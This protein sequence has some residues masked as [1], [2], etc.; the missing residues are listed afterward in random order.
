MSETKSNLLDIIDMVKRYAFRFANFGI[1]LLGLASFTI[2][3]WYFDPI[4]DLS[5]K[6]VVTLIYA[7]IPFLNF[8]DGFNTELKRS[9]FNFT[10]FWL[11]ILPTGTLIAVLAHR[12]NLPFVSV[13]VLS[14]LVSLPLLWT[15]WQLAKGD[16]LL[17]FPIIPSIIA[18]SLYLVRPIS[19]EG[20]VLDYVFLPLPIISVGSVAWALATKRLLVN[21]RQWRWCLTWG[22]MFESLTMLF[23]VAPL[24][25]LTMLAVDALDFGDIWVAVSGV[26]VGVLFGGAV[27][28]PLR[29]FLLSLGNLSTRC[30]CKGGHRLLWIRL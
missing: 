6:V 17:L 4:E 1:S 12:A 10:N 24:I 11:M 25:A 3:I 15:F 21:A 7:V 30:S 18:A 5:A 22:P 19:S 8:V 26:A 16:R 20:I 29:Q 2:L 9:E 13:N 27:S 14:I 23:I 28:T